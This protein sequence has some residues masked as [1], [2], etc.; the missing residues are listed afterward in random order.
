MQKVSHPTSDAQGFYTLPLPQR[1]PL[2]LGA[3]AWY[4]HRDRLHRVA[5]VSLLGLG[6][7]IF[8]SFW[9]VLI[10]YFVPV[11]HHFAFSGDNC[12][13]NPVPLPQLSDHQTTSGFTSTS[14][15]TLSIKGYPVFSSQTCISPTE[16]PVAGSY[17]T[18][19]VAP[20][21]NPL[22]FKKI[23]VEVPALPTATPLFALDQALG[24]NSVATFALSNED[25]QLSYVL[26]TPEASSPC[27]VTLTELA[28]SLEPLGL[29]SGTSY[30]LRLEQSFKGGESRTIFES[31]VTTL[32]PTRVTASSIPEGSTVYDTPTSLVL[33][34]DKALISTDTPALT[35][36]STNETIAII[37]RV[38]GQTLSLDFATALPRSNDFRLTL[39]T[40]TATDGSALDSS[41][42][43]QFRTSGGPHVSSTS[44]GT[45][46]VSPSTNISVKFDVKLQPG[47]AL[48]NFVRLH[49]GQTTY[50]ASLSLSDNTITINPA[51]D[52]PR[53][54]NFTITV[55]EGLVSQYGIGGGKPWSY[56]SRTI[57]QI[58]STIGTS[59]RGRSIT[60]YRFG[61]GSSKIVFV[62]GTHGNEKS[63]VA[64]MNAW[65]D[66]LE[67]HAHEL[68][69]NRS[70]IVIPNL[71]PDGYASSSRT[72]ANNVDLNRNFPSNDW[73]SSVQMPGGQNLPQGGGITPLDQPE[74]QAMA[75]FIQAQSPRLVLTYHAVAKVVISND[76]GDSITQSQ[77][78]AELSGYPFTSNANSHGTFEYATTGEFEDWLAD[79]E[80]IPGIL[81]ELS[82]MSSN[83]FPTHRSAMWAMAQL[84]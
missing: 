39:N 29:K 57:C 17:D 76:T 24:T 68:P 20:F 37:S 75:S 5:L 80:N 9:S 82:S 44:I 35:N 60:A 70:I 67:L 69:S 10:G 1:Q 51:A 54:T 18:L 12:F 38:D 16:L 45:S 7:F 61:S 63:S 79:K 25:T 59:V 55:S 64:T 14:K 34:F 74:S 72:N 42:V 32:S 66:Y 15:P 21:G 77:K 36:L 62:G 19:Q 48:S 27:Q 13:F 43:L 30:P 52:L 83:Q 81:I 53:C 56:N 28:C 26:T 50:P 65:I 78:Y 58:T 8:L 6:V 4:R 46:K 22:V 2:L 23:V 47:Q 33:T 31:T 11:R 73:S 84:P 71:N 40:V 3:G 49:S 41:Y